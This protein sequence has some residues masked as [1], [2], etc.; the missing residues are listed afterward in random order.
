MEHSISL[1]F[2]EKWEY[3]INPNIEATKKLRLPDSGI[4]IFV[5]EEIENRIYVFSN[6]GI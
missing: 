5:N 2:P 6:E 1:D 3:S 4:E